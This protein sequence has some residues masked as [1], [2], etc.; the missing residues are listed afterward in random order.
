MISPY[1]ALRFVIVT[2]AL[3]IALG[4]IY[5]PS[6]GHGFVKD[7]FVWIARSDVTSRKGL[8]LLLD[9][10][11][12][13]FR[14]V[15]SLSFGVN[16]LLFDLRPLGYGL[17][18][19]GLLLAC[20][21]AVG[22]LGQALS[23]RPYAALFG[24]AVWA[25]NFHGINSATLWISGRTAL[26]LTLFGVI[27]AISFRKGR[28][29]QSSLFLFLAMLS[30]EEAVALPLVLVVLW[31]CSRTVDRDLSH[32][33]SAR[34]L[35]PLIVP[36]VGYLLLRARS[37]AF[38]PTTAPAYYQLGPA[39]LVSNLIPYADRSATFAV[40]ALALLWVAGGMKPFRLEPAERSAIGFGALWLA[41]GFA[42]TAFL[43]VR[44]SLYACFPSVGVA[45]IAAAFSGAMCRSIP[46]RREIMAGALC[47]VMPFALWPVYHARNRR[48][49]SEAELSASVLTQL[50]AFASLMSHDPLRIVV[51]DDRS[52]RPSLD[53]AFGT[54]IQEAVDL[55]IDRRVRVWLDPPPTEAALAGISPPASVDAILALRN[56]L[57]KVEKPGQ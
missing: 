2:L 35:V 16:R 9:A 39:H 5:L 24:A 38:T 37:G 49:V 57:L 53:D 42:L 36:L 14:P 30:K 3:S 33:V 29:L 43:P 23:L 13:F 8:A 54:L 40:M 12:G 25:F 22:R 55:T 52:A 11:T 15:V 50:T 45:I 10:P 7:D 56:G 27:G 41:G 32:R 20:A 26:L 17:T 47:V 6:V 31:I 18:N 21:F 34:H 19:F 44:S 51:R 4:L 1:S 46:S 48:S 28:Y